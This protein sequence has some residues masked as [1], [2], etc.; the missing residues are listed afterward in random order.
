MDIE[1]A[2]INSIQMQCLK[3]E[4]NGSAIIGSYWKN[5]N[6]KWKSKRNKKMEIGRAKM[7]ENVEKKVV[8]LDASTIQMIA[9]T[10][11]VQLPLWKLIF[12]ACPPQCM[13]LSSFVFILHLA[14]W[15]PLPIMKRCS[16]ILFIK[17]F[18][19]STV[20]KYTYH[21]YKKP[22]LCTL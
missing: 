3:I 17:F 2:S 11:M 22:F 12:V 4:N 9:N 1:W 15:V 10:K 6:T 5:G 14:M 13:P 20:T 18:S 8:K 21:Y 19:H 7:D 16:S